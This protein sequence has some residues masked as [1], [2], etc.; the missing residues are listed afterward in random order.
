M[1]K[2]FPEPMQ[3]VSDCYAM[4]Q[5]GFITSGICLDMTQSSVFLPSQISDYLHSYIAIMSRKMSGINAF[6]F[7]LFILL[8]LCSS[9]PSCCCWTSPPTTWTQTPVYGWRRSSHRECASSANVDQ[10]SSHVHLRCA[11]RP[12]PLSGSGESLCS[13]PTLKTS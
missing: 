3:V 12:D 6:L 9:S 4:K 7:P 10:F 5:T 8:E 2:P 11:E 13:S 1:T